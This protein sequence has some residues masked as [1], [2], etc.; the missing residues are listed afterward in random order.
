MSR[1]PATASFLTDS[2]HQIMP[3]R[4][5]IHVGVGA[6]VGAM[7]QWRDWSVPCAWLID[8]NPACM[9]WIEPLLKS[10]PSW[11]ARIATVAE[12]NGEAPFFLASN[13]A[14]S[15]L[16]APGSLAALW[17]NLHTVKQ[18][19]HATSRLDALLDMPDQTQNGD[20]LIVDCLT[21]LDILK[22]AS[23]L[24]KHCS[25]LWLRTLLQPLPDENTGNTLAELEAFLEPSGF[26][27]IRIT[28]CNHP[29]IGEVLFVRNWF[30]YLAPTIQAFSQEKVLLT[31][32]TTTLAQ[33]NTT[34]KRENSDLV[35]YN[36]ALQ[37]EKANLDQHQ[38][39]LRQALATLGKERDEAVNAIAMQQNKTAQLTQALDEQ[40]H[41]FSLCQHQIDALIQD[42]AELIGFNEALEQASALL[43]TNAVALQ[44]K[45][46]ELAEYQAKCDKELIKLANERDEASK[47]I[48]EYQDKIAQLAQT[49]DGQNKGIA[50]FEQQISG[51]TQELSGLT[52]TNNA[53]Q[54]EI[55]SLQSHISAL[56]Q[57]NALFHEQQRDR[58]NYLATLD[59]EREETAKLLTERE[60]R[61]TQLNQSLEQEH[62]T[63]V[64]SRLKIDALISDNADLMAANASLQM[65][66][67]AV[68]SANTTLRQEN[69]ALEARQLDLD[70]EQATLCNERQEMATLLTERQHRVEQLVQALNKQNEHITQC[71]IRIDAIIADKTDLL[72]A[73]A[74]LQNEG[75]RSQAEIASMRQASTRLQ[76]EM[77]TLR[78]E[79]SRLQTDFNLLQGEKAT[80]AEQQ[81]GL[82]NQVSHM[83]AE[84]DE[85]EKLLTEHQN[86][87]VQLTQSISE[88][89]GT[90][91]SYLSQIGQ[92]EAENK[93]LSERL[94]N[95]TTALSLDR[96]KQIQLLVTLQHEMDKKQQA[97]EQQ[98]SLQQDAAE[99]AATRH[100]SLVQA[101]DQ[102][103]EEKQSLTEEKQRLANEKQSLTED[104]QK[105]AKEKQILID[106]KQILIEEKKKLEVSLKDKDRQLQQFD[107]ELSESSR[108]Q[109]QMAEE[110][111]RA[112]A[113]IDLIKDVLLRE[114][115]L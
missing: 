28:E 60:T 41:H 105:L 10:N 47:S 89:T 82:S 13:P 73:N 5:L 103:T 91:N 95:E 88:Q 81:L 26:R 23:N 99:H 50:Q 27:C 33:E 34:L 90:V 32:Q 114:Q 83:T 57:E 45:N 37:Q 115:G 100:A 14:E 55:A 58:D 43:Q 78:Q 39:S 67:A 92:L 18:E 80:L 112:E 7:H 24:L 108:R 38:S 12:L 106:E 31:Q 93:T 98:L 96:D 42:K 9:D 61:I 75:T 22:G 65:E 36:T 20:W 109:Q 25:V 70:Q 56:Q 97:I 101:C 6:G 62:H 87:I 64:Q 68:Q 110:L 46:K 8:A 44:Q 84:R 111:V 59:I 107:A 63:T 40:L 69:L 1:T 66:K 113:Q 104:Q 85:Q 54:H 49:L 51:L 16:I 77:D 21:A 102:L 94:V 30:A 2:L 74:D 11:Q 48:R 35:A 72:A 86:R 53:S 3:P 29:A 15:S 4:R 52:A 71:Q 76:I 79:Y 19:M 17:P